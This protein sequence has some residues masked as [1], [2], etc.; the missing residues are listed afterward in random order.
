MSETEKRYTVCR[1]PKVYDA[2]GD[3]TKTW[4]VY[5]YYHSPITGEMVRFRDSTGIN[6]HQNP[7]DRRKVADKLCKSY[8]RKLLKGWSPFQSLKK[9]DNLRLQKMSPRKF[10]D[11]FDVK[12][13]VELYLE[14]KIQSRV[15]PKTVKD[16]KGALNHYIRWMEMSRLIDSETYF[17]TADHAVKFKKYL[18]EEKQLGNKRINFILTT[19]RNFFVFLKKNNR[20]RENPFQQVELLPDD[21][22]PSRYFPAWEISMIKEY[23]LAKDPQLWIFLQFIYYELMRPKE[24][25]LLRIQNIDFSRR[26]IN[27]PGFTYVHGKRVRM[28]KNG[29]SQTIVIPE[30]FIEQLKNYLEEYRQQ[31]LNTG[32]IPDHYFI[33]TAKRRP[34]ERPVSH[35]YFNRRFRKMREALEL[36]Y[37]YNPYGFKHTGAIRLANSGASIKDIQMHARHH[38]LDETDKYI[39]TMVPVDSEHLRTHFPPL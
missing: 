9:Y 25:K 6:R 16:Y 37:D 27:I 8:R 34:G 35:S 29:K 11:H 39:R 28:S 13:C 5:Y 26:V 22:V 10:A 36:P 14:N 2:D 17:L 21:S 33:F 23:T 19:L 4:F 20:A 24:I 38:S 1:L 32:T 12:K 15:E 3:I 18:V 30:P 7:S 31:S